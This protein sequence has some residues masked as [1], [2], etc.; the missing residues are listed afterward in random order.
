MRRNCEICG[1]PLG[2]EKSLVINTVHRGICLTL[3]NHHSYY[4][5]GKVKVSDVA[6]HRMKD[7]IIRN[8]EI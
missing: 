6:V 4:W 3:V 8:T 7:I 1:Q 5:Q 2:K